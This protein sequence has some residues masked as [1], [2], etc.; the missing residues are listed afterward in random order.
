[1]TPLFSRNVARS[2]RTLFGRYDLIRQRKRYLPRHERVTD[3]ATSNGLHL[4]LRS[5]P[6]RAYPSICENGAPNLID[7]VFDGQTPFGNYHPH[8]R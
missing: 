5:R 7:H 3:P 8:L 4:F 1:M 6:S 2:V